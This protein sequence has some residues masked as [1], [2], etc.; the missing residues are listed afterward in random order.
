MAEL[1]ASNAL[2]IRVSHILETVLDGTL[3]H[4]GNI[5]DVRGYIAAVVMLLSTSI[6]KSFGYTV[7]VALGME[8]PAI[9][10]EVTGTQD[11]MQSE[12]SRWLYPAFGRL[13][14]GEVTL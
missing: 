3:R 5:A 12:L 11:M 2:G 4:L 9:A 1:Q 14:G 8:T 7:A 6:S 13:G 10:S